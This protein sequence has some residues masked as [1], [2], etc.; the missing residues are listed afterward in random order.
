MN[1]KASKTAEQFAIQMD[2]FARAGMSGAVMLNFGSL[3]GHCREGGII[4][5]DSDMDLGIISSMVTIE[6][7]TEYVRLVRAAGLTEYRDMSAKRPDT[8]RLFWMSI[9]K[10]PA[11]IGYKCCHW[12]WIEHAGIL[13][14]HK[15]PG[16]LIKGIPASMLQVGPEVEFLGVKV[17][18]PRN[19]GA[20]LDFWYPDWATPRTGGNSETRFHMKVQDW[21]DEKTWKIEDRGY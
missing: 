15:G 7:E 3:L 10:D 16:S 9:R 13:W 11:G 4:G 17:R 20:C 6:Q 5:Y 2:C 21:K 12:F 8:Q 18:I 14:H 19:A 1:S